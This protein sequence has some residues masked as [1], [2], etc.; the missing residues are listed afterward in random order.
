MAIVPQHATAMADG[1]G[2]AVFVFPDVPQGELWCGTTQIRGAPAT[3]VGIVTASGEFLGEMFGAGSWGPWTCGATRILSITTTGLTPGTQYQ[4]VWHADSQ[5]AEFS[6]YPS[7]ITPT[8]VSGGG[9]VIVANFPAIQTVDGTV[10]VG[11]LPQAHGVNS[12]QATM[13]GVSAINL[14]AFAAVQGVVLAGKKTN[15]NPIAVGGALVS[16]SNGML[17]EPGEITP[18]LP[19]ANSDDL[20]AIGTSG[21]VLSYLVT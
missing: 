14:A 2:D 3:A 20:Y 19:V 8:A 21:D 15:T 16:T 18:L 10:D 7:P 1:S 5:G 17:V 13:N 11:A 6:T 12:G 9:S 4:A